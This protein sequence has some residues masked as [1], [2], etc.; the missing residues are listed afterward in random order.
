M[1]RG[2]EAVKGGVV[3]AQW[4]RLVCCRRRIV[5]RLA[6]SLLLVAPT[7]SAGEGPARATSSEGVVSLPDLLAHAAEHAPENRLARVGRARGDVAR[8]AASPLFPSNPTLAAM[9]GPRFAGDRRATDFQLSLSQAVEVAGQR[10]LRRHVAD[11]VA[12]RLDA[13]AAAVAWHVRCNVVRDYHLAAVAALGIGFAERA[14]RSAEE[15]LAVMQ[16]R[17]AA[18]DATAMDARRSESDVARAR[19][20]LVVAQRD[21][22]LALIDLAAEAGW[23]PTEPLGTAPDLEPPVPPPPLA[24]LLPSPRGRHPELAAR[25]A[26]RVEADARAEL[27]A[28]AGW[29]N[30]V[31]GV[32]LT[33]EGA[34]GSPEN[35]IVLGTLELPLPFWQRNQEQRAESRSEALAARV[36]EDLEARA[37]TAR[38]ARAHAELDAAAARV[39]LLAQSSR[40]SLAS[41]L[42]LLQ[43]G[44]EAGEVELDDLIDGRER[45]LEAERAVLEATADYYRA[46]ADLES[47]SGAELPRESPA[48]AA[49]PSQGARGAEASE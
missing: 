45:L 24:K 3:G 25:R 18:G 27:A 16:R 23:P 19:E 21:R 46:R 28:R 43:K 7:I 32:Q 49:L 48:P 20:A 42:E 9:L 29:P 34:V 22:R 8:A 11:H 14:L 31:L 37:V 26:A 47:A 36:N 39:A 33:R 30:P 2:V 38:V 17:V 35:D 15:V 10:G 12:R 5:W 13:E 41:A 4:A 6:S 44:F 40:P 1:R